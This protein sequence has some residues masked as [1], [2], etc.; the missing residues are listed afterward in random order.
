MNREEAGPRRTIPSADATGRE[1]RLLDPH[2]LRLLRR[3]D[4]VPAEALTRIAVELSLGLPRWQ[5][6]GYLICV[7]IFLLCIVF[8]V[9]WKLAGRRGIDS[10]DLVLWPTNLGVFSFGAAKFWQSRRRTRAKE[11]RGTMLKSRRCTPCG[12]D[13][14]RLPTSDCGATTCPAFGHVWQLHDSS[15]HADR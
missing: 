3:F 6:L 1:V 10:V 8:Q 7:A 2:A 5:R 12:F 9:V 15:L 11:V 14:R 4:I 13:I